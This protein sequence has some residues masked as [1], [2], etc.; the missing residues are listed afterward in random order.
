MDYLRSAYSTNIW[1]HNDTTNLFEKIPITWFK[2]P[3]NAIP[4]GVYHQYGSANWQRGTPFPD[5][6][7]EVL[8][9]PRTYSK[10]S[11][12][13]GYFGL[14]HCGSDNLWSGQLSKLSVA[15]PS[16]PTGV[17]S[18]CGLQGSPCPYCDG[19]AMPLHCTII[20]VNG[21]G[22]FAQFNGFHTMAGTFG[23]VREYDAYPIDI[24]WT[25]N[26]A[27]MVVNIGNF[28]THVGVTYQSSSHA[29]MNPPN[30]WTLTGSNGVGTV[31]TFG[32]NV[33]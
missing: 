6:V 9:D 24:T 32:L 12:V 19:G 30:S 33:S 5:K 7:G 27:G 28:L 26:A 23:C 8:G 11:P 29:C 4:L 10:G 2:A 3:T 1:I 18:C 21:S 15:L 16:R 20:V 31:P 22:D 25:V 17:P 14:N 13:N